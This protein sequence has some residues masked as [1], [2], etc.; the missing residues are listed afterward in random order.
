V[1]KK[2]IKQ[3]VI[4]SFSDYDLFRGSWAR[5]PV[6]PVG[7][8]FPRPVSTRPGSPLS[9]R[10]G[11]GSGRGSF[12][13][14]RLG[15]PA[16]LSSQRPAGGKTS[17]AKSGLPKKS[18]SRKAGTK[19]LKSP[20]K[21]KK[22][23]T[24]KFNQEEKALLRFI[25]RFPEEV[26]KAGQK[27]EPA[28]IANYLFELAQKYNQFYNQHSILGKKSKKDDQNKKSFDKTKKAGFGGFSR[29]SSAQERTYFRLALTAGVAQ[30]L[31]NGLELLGIET[32]EKM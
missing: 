18:F 14:S 4:F 12:A 7:S 3:R 32:L 22:K 17:L 23:K 8:R 13:S 28:I 10:S 5:G 6:S 29:P 30:V 20:P 19:G 27:I 21:P 9:A 25:Y 2:A 24:F 11:L 1:L 15:K 31:K 16:S 26:L